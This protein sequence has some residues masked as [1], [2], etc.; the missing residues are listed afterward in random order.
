MSNTGDTNEI[1]MESQ[2]PFTN[3][4][5][6][7]A[8]AQKLPKQLSLTKSISPFGTSSDELLELIGDRNVEGVIARVETAGGVKL[9]AEQLHTDLTQGLSAVD[10]LAARTQVFGHNVLPKGQQRTLLRIL[11]EAASDK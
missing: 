8:H 5:H 7:E 6:E 10:N 9:L 3:T 1:S 4:L 2:Q 11:L